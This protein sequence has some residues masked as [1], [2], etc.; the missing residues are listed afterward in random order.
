MSSKEEAHALLAQAETVR[1]RLLADRQELLDRVVEIDVLLSRLP[2]A[3]QH[4]APV[5]LDEWS[6]RRA[7]LAATTIGRGG[8]PVNSRDVAH[9]VAS[10]YGTK[11]TALLGPDR[12]VTIARARHVAMFLARKLTRESFPEL[13]G[14]FGSR[15]HTTVIAAVRKIEEQLAVD[16]ELRLEVT[17]IEQALSQRPVPSPAETA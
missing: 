8:Q 16:P 14:Y 4:P 17:E 11:V 10:F 7:R 15:D 3:E 6:V 2:G 1:A 5:S 9:V 12:H 13:G